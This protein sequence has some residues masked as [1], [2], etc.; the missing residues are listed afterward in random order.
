MRC[1]CSPVLSLQQTFA[2]GSTLLLK[3]VKLLMGN[4]ES[5]AVWMFLAL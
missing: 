5:V 2:E 1:S 4:K 3:N